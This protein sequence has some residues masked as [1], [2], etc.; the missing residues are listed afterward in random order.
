VFTRAGTLAG[1]DIGR[2]WPAV[3]ER[4]E[5]RTAGRWSFFARA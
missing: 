4:E 5:G 2:G 3:D 1:A